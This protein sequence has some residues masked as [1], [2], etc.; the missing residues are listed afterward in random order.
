VTICFAALRVTEVETVPKVF[1]LRSSAEVAPTISPVTFHQRQPVSEATITAP[2]VNFVQSL[3][4]DA[5]VDFAERI[6]TNSL[7][8]GTFKYNFVSPSGSVLNPTGGHFGDGDGESFT[9]FFF[10]TGGFLTGA[11]FTGAFLV[12]LAFGVGVGLFVAATADVRESPKNTA[13][14]SAIALSFIDLAPT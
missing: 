5:R 4:C 12:T 6:P 3:I 2:Q 10:F 1:N 14:I 11:F 7:A 8:V 9:F 13:V